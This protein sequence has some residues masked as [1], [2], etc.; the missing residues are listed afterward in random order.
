MKFNSN[1][2][3]ETGFQPL[4]IEQAAQV[5]QEANVSLIRFTY[6]YLWEQW[7]KGNLTLFFL[8][9]V[10]ILVGTVFYSEYNFHGNYAHGFFYAVNVGYSIGWGILGR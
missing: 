1:Q 6:S 10:W 5:V 3:D 8:W 9:F 4:S 2:K 7:D